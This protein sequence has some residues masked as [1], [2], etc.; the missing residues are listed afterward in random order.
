MEYHGLSVSHSLTHQSTPSE[1]KISAGCPAPKSNHFSTGN[2]SGRHGSSSRIVLQQ[3]D[4]QIMAPEKFARLVSSTKCK[5][6]STRIYIVHHKLIV[7]ST[8]MIP[9]QWLIF[10]FKTSSDYCNVHGHA[11][12]ATKLPDNT[13]STAIKNQTTISETTL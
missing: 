3:Q 5:H 2:I 13:W 8:N 4:G 11:K 10:S 12:L 9:C 1:S 7:K 6:D